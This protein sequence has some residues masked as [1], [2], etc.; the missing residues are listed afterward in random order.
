MLEKLYET[1]SSG[2]RRQGLNEAHG[3]GFGRIVSGQLF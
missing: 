1:E 2:V 3:S